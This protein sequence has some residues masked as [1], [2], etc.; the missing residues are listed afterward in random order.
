MERGRN[1]RE[2]TRG[3]TES[4]SSFWAEPESVTAA[5][6][7]LCPFGNALHQV[8]FCCLWRMRCTNFQSF[9]RTSRLLPGHLRSPIFLGKSWH[10]SFDIKRGRSHPLPGHVHFQAVLLRKT[11]S[12]SFCFVLQSEH[13][14][15]QRPVDAKYLRLSSSVN[16]KCP[17][18]PHSIHRYFFT[19]LGDIPLA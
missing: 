6:R 12:I 14:M 18:S 7:V 10:F 9:S 1:S 8:S 17:R 5:R 13:T 11:F 3:E 16:F 4:A 19:S 2:R 15:M